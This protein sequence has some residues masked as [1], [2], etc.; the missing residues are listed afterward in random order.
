MHALVARDATDAPG[1]AAEGLRHIK[2]QCARSRDRASPARVHQS[3]TGFYERKLSI[4]SRT[5]ASTVEGRWMDERGEIRRG[6]S[7]SLRAFP[8]PGKIRLVPPSRRRIV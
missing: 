2:E 5:R 6:S 4:S 1:V 3:V 8:S 7:S